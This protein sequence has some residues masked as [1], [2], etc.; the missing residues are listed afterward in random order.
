MYMSLLAVVSKP[1]QR[2]Y[3]ADKVWS[4]LGMMLM[5]WLRGCHSDECVLT[6]LLLLIK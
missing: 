4:D 3:G 5:S 1:F 6:E 2:G